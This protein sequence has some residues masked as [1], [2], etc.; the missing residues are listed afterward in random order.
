M[1]NKTTYNLF[2]FLSTLTRNIIEVF[3]VI[4][5]YNKGYSINNILI[6]LLVMYISGIITNYISLKSNYKVVLIISYFTYGISYLYLSLMN[7][8]IYNLLLLAVLLS[9]SNYSYHAI[10]QLH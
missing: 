10:I 6:F 8:N 1:T 9:I 5:L 2:L 3:S 4:I 7:N